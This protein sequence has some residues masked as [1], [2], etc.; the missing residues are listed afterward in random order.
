M[1]DRSPRRLAALAVL[2][3]A[4]VALIATTPG[5]PTARVDASGEVAVAPDDPGE[6]EVRFGVADPGENRIVRVSVHAAVPGGGDPRVHATAGA[7]VTGQEEAG[8]IG[9]GALELDPTDCA[10]GCEVVTTLTASWVGPPELEVRTAWRVELAVEYESDVSGEDPVSA[11]VVRGHEPAA[12][13]IAWPAFG[14]ALAALA[15]VALVAWGGSL[16]LVRLVLAAGIAVPAA[17]ALIPTLPYLSAMPARFAVRIDWEAILAAGA[18]LAL[19]LAAGVGVWRAALGMDAVLRVVG[20]LA[21]L[22]VGLAWWQVVDHMPA[23]RGHE[24]VLLTFALALPCAA[25]IGG[26]PVRGPA[27][28]TR[29]IGAALSLVIAAQLLMAGASLLVAG[30]LVLSFLA[31][32][33]SPGARAPDVG[34]LAMGSIP[35]LVAVGFVAGLWAWRRGSRAV[36]LAADAPLALVVVLGAG[37]MLLQPETGFLAPTPESRVVGVLAALTVLGAMAGVVVLPPPVADDEQGQGEG[38][39]GHQIPRVPREGDGVQAGGGA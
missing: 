26:A 30:A 3:V 23:Y 35:L 19:I 32:L 37:W 15:G 21:A 20:W 10:R 14:A 8:A 36:L 4:S 25:A 31:S 5:P 13:R 11:S 39:Q 27:R 34:S 12:P 16:G 9:V 1:T 33:L 38:G 18:A 28:A 24:L 17:I 22:G 7:V 6:V 29:R 2:V